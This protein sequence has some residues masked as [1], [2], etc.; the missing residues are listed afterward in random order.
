M[1]EQRFE[2][3]VGKIPFN[4]ESWRYSNWGKRPVN[5]IIYK[6]F[7]NEFV[8]VLNI[9]LV[10]IGVSFNIYIYIYIYMHDNGFY[11][12]NGFCKVG[13]FVHIDGRRGD[14]IEWN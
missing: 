9:G 3:K 2:F 12:I 14:S 1:R 10:F 13:S 11:L 8:Y 4:K 6:S 5:R 7:S